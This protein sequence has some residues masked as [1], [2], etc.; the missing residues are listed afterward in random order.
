M[1]EASP[2]PN[3][4]ETNFV[5]ID[6][7]AKTMH[8]VMISAVGEVKARRDAEHKAE[9]IISEITNLVA[10]FRET[11]T[12]NT[13]GVGIPGLVNCATDKELLLSDQPSIAR[14]ASYMT[15]VK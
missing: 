14:D 6:I 15:L 9:N 3:Q 12:I 2:M 8:A 4:L 1:R 7:A 13:Y 10:G 5:G 11:G